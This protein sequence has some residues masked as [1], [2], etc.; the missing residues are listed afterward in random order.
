ME[1]RGIS[2]L[3][4]LKNFEG[5]LVHDRAVKAALKLRLE[6]L[7]H[8]VRSEAEQVIN[9][10]GGKLVNIRI[11]DATDWAVY[12]E[13]LPKFEIYYF[14]QRYSPEFEDSLM[15]LYSKES[16]ELGISAEDVTQFTIL[17]ANALI[18]Y[19]KK[20]LKKDLPKISR[21]L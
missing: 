20:I 10:I 12:V 14:L 7:R 16:L 3:V 19:A 6:V 11:D 21:Y 15:A 17:Y 13:P 2:H 8:I 1:N 18:Y 4:S 9:S 5:G